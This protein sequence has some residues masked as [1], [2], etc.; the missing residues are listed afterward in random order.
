L[1]ILLNIS[2]ITREKP[3]VEDWEKDEEGEDEDFDDELLYFFTSL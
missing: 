1:W 3:W 2:F